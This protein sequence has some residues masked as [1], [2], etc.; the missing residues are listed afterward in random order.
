M[1]LLFLCRGSVL[2]IWGRLHSTQDQQP[3]ILDCLLFWCW[4][5]LSHDI[6]KWSYLGQDPGVSIPVFFPAEFLACRQTLVVMCFCL[7]EKSAVVKPALTYME[8]INQSLRLCLS[9]GF[10]YLNMISFFYIFILSAVFANRICFMYPF[11]ITCLDMV[12]LDVLTQGNLI[13]PF[14]VRVFGWIINS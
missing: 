6:D 7:T 14:C 13:M 1:S 8:S 12:H 10:C 4:F 3:Q 9:G 11:F 2:A 5:L